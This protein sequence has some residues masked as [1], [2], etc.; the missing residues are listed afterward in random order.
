VG[1]NGSAG[2]AGHRSQRPGAERT[3]STFYSGVRF[4]YLVAPTYL[5]APASGSVVVFRFHGRLVVHRVVRAEG[6]TLVTRG[7]NRDFAGRV[8]AKDVV[9]VVVFA[10]SARILY[11]LLI[12][13]AVIELARAL[14]EKGERGCK[15]NMLL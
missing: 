12:A 13:V 11:P 8:R 6:D 10:V 7:D 14:L 15:R 1:R 9:G 4:F 3:S 5:A 2:T